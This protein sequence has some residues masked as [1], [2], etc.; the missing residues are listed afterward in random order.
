MEN[1]FLMFLFGGFFKIIFSLLCYLLFYWYDLHTKNFT[2]LKCIIQYIV[3]R[4]HNQHLN[5][6]PEY[7]HYPEKK[8]VSVSSHSSYPIPGNLIYFLLL[9]VCLLQAFHINGIIGLLCLAS[10]I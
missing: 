1:F 4:L 3:T 8:P 9:W 7:F 2:I 10:F 6:I 5:Q